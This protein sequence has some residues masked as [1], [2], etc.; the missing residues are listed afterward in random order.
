MLLIICGHP[1]AILQIQHEEVSGCETPA[2]E[3][4]TRMLESDSGARPTRFLGK[5]FISPA[6]HLPDPHRVSPCQ[7]VKH[8][9]QA[10]SNVTPNCTCL[11]LRSLTCRFTGRIFLFGFIPCEKGKTYGSLQRLP[12]PHPLSTIH[13]FS[14]KICQPQRCLSHRAHSL[15]TR[16]GK[17][18]REQAEGEPVAG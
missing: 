16:R 17:W 6:I 4:L 11:R 15:R 18:D 12:F 7:S 14:A 9:A 5:A 3:Q 1:Q 13:R 8:L 10:D 2:E